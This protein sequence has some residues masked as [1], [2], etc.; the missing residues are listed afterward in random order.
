MR[1]RTFITLLGGGSLAAALGPAAVAQGRVARIGFLASLPPS[2]TPE[3]LQVFRSALSERGYTEGQNLKIEYRWAEQPEETTAAELV[4]LN[5]DVIVAWATPA[6]TAA[7]RATAKVPIVMVGVADPIGA[8]FVNSLSRPGGNITGTTNLARDL[9]GKLLEL[10]LEISPGVNQVFVL[11]VPHN[12]ASALLLREVEVAVRALG[13]QIV[14]VE[15]AAADELDAAFARMVREKAKGVIALA[16]PLLIREQ[17]RVAELAQKARLPVVFSRRENVEAGGL[18]A[19]GASLRVQ[20]RETAGF[21]DKILKGAN[22]ADL[23]V[24]QPTRLE[25]IVNLKAA[26]ALGLDIPPT[27]LARADEVIE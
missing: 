21:V 14:L 1:R 3:L 26:K 13:L 25:L 6:V 19:Y 27:L 18:I 17:V 20:F 7:R 15:I 8:G 23:P 22:P 4:A 5:V 9:G 16:D 2:A 11:R 24:E 12:P 10:L